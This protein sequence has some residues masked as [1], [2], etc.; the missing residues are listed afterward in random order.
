MMR[1]HGISPIVIP[2]DI[3]EIIPIGLEVNEAVMY[4]ALE[5][6][7]K[8]TNDPRVPINAWVV[9]ADTVVYKDRVVVGKPADANDAFDTLKFLCGE[10]HEVYTGVAIVQKSGSHRHA[11]YERTRVFFKNYSDKEIWDYISSGE[12]FDKAGGYAI[13]GKFSEYIDYIEGDRNNVIGFPWDRFI[14]EWENMSVDGINEED[15]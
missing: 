3:D 15:R 12:P 10:S 14:R 1:E 7:K 9:A 11:F 5:K 8:V 6:A 13:Q 2:A 4:L